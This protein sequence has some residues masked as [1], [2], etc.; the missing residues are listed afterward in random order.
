MKTMRTKQ[1]NTK[2]RFVLLYILSLLLIAVVMSAFWQKM[3]EKKP[4]EATSPTA[5]TDTIFIQFDTVLHTK[6][7]QLDD[8]FNAYVK[9]RQG[10]AMPDSTELTAARSSMHNALDNIE[11]AASSSDEGP[12]KT[13]LTLVA[14]KFRKEL[15]DKETLLNAI[16]A[17]N[18]KPDSAGTNRSGEVER[19]N[20]LLQEKEQTIAAL[21]K[22]PQT[23]GNNASAELQKTIADKDK[24]I[25]SLQNE[26]RQKEAALQNASSS[27]K[28]AGGDW[29]QKY[30]SLK[31]S[32]DKVSASEKTLKTAY[33][34]LA[35]DNRRLLSQLQS[36]R[37]G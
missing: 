10:G 31:A 5:E 27:G 26:V 8:L 32:F 24:T 7:E 29:Q 13:A 28:P 25:A 6:A 18:T 37:K 4:A 9:G 1:G 20:R 3:T 12:K 17:L 15:A 21:Q 22:A 36:A 23:T 33:Q 30:Q 14:A 2:L 16:T 35:D 34:T 11:Q 19:L